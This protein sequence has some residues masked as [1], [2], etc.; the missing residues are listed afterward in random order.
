VPVAWRDVLYTVLGHD[1]GD[2][3]AAFSIANGEVDKD[4]NPTHDWSMETGGGIAVSTA[5][6]E[7]VSSKFGVDVVPIR[8]RERKTLLD[9]VGIIVPVLAIVH[10][11]KD[12]GSRGYGPQHAI[13][14][15]NA[16]NDTYRMAN[17]SGGD[18]LASRSDLESRSGVEI[19]RPEGGAYRYALYDGGYGW[20]AKM[21]D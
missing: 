15:T 5:L 19:V 21:P 12:D 1:P 14:L 10:P 16:T 9:N 8:F 3:R 17:V 18:V 7:K 11:V 20:T 13:T 6:L 2:L 4:G